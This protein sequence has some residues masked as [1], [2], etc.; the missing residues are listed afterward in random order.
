MTTVSEE[1][2]KSQRKIPLWI[3]CVV[4]IFVIF[5]VIKHR[6]HQLTPVVVSASRTQARAATISSNVAHSSPAQK[7]ASSVQHAMTR[8]LKADKSLPLV[9]PSPTARG[10]ATGK[11]FKLSVTGVKNHLERYD[12][13][14]MTDMPIVMDVIYGRIQKLSEQLD[15]GLDPNMAVKMGPNPEDTATLL[16]Y[17]IGAGQRA[18][19]KELVAR[20]A[21]TNLGSPL[22]EAASLSQVDVVKFLLEHGANPNQTG[23]LGDTAL[24]DAI[25]MGDYPAVKVLLK[26]GADPNQIGGRAR[27]YMDQST[28]PSVVAIR[29]LLNGG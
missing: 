11:F 28:N 25:I 13:N 17:A 9:I 15:A 8:P 6:E 26:A 20:G 1:K 27:H 10:P 21:S 18:V 7:S 5:Y 12:P 23:V 16:S 24:R 3:M 2:E 4:A 22:T 29:K 19:I 14:V